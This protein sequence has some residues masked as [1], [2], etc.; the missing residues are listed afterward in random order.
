MCI[1]YKCGQLI[2]YRCCV[3]Q[4][5]LSVQVQENLNLQNEYQQLKHE[6]KAMKG[7]STATSVRPSPR[8]SEEKAKEKQKS[9]WGAMLGLGQSK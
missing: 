5:K 3:S 1:E 2:K 4:R 9:G 6:M 8:S 7:Q